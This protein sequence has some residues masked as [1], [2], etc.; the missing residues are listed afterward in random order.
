MYDSTPIKAYNYV[1][2]TKNADEIANLVHETVFQFKSEF[3]INNQILRRTQK[4]QF[5]VG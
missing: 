1:E 2:D 3:F 4:E 5:I